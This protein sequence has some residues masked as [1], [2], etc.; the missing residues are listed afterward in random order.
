MSQNLIS[1]SRRERAIALLDDTIHA[2]I[3]HHRLS[4]KITSK[5][6][7]NLTDGRGMALPLEYI[8]VPQKL[9]KLV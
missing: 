6:K 7:K 2:M 5:L 9:F 4:Q 1:L 3:D 8:D